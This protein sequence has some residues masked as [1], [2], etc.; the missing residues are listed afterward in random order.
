MSLGNLHQLGVIP[1]TKYDKTTFNINGQATLSSRFTISGGINFIRGDNDKAQQGSNTS[2]V[3]LGLLRT[4]TTFD[5][6]NG[7]SD[8]VDN[9]ASYVL[10]NGKERDYRGGPGYDNPY[11][12]VNRVIFHEDLLRAFGYGQASYQLSSTG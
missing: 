3:M 5:N 6:S 2:G 9:P 4:P 1:Q 11:W 8:P 10:P 7:L 12:T